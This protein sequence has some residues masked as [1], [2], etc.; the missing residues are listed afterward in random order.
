MFTET[1]LRPII[2]NLRR[3]ALS[4]TRSPDAAEDLLQTTLARVWAKRHTYQDQNTLLGW[5]ATTMHNEHVSQIRADKRR[6]QST[7]ADHHVI[8]HRASA[9]TN[10]VIRD[11]TRALSSLPENQQDV[12]HLIAFEGLDYD[13]AANF[14]A[15]PPGTVRSRLH[16]S[17]ATLREALG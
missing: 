5:C 2:P 11:V 9:E 15:I 8:D 16:R 1:Q 12:I 14:L 6:I 3:Y 4:L 7:T 13:T 10:I 17:R